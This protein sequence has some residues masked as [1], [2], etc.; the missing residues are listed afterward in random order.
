MTS[1]NLNFH[2][3]SGRQGPAPGSVR[4]GCFTRS[5]TPKALASRLLQGLTDTIDA[6]LLF[7][8]LSLLCFG[9]ILQVFLHICTSLKDETNK[10][11]GQVCSKSF[12]KNE[13]QACINPRVGCISPQGK[14]TVTVQLLTLRCK[15]CKDIDGHD[16]KTIV[17]PTVELHQLLLTL[18]GCVV[19]SCPHTPKKDSKKIL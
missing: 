17:S 8:Q 2:S 4:M 19:I 3:F 9:P 5:L 16:N 13:R 6:V 10:M 1:K 15:I 11:L 12:S 7:S 18:Y 14:F